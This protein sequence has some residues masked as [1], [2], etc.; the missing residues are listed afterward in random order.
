[1]VV[2]I[3][4]LGLVV[5]CAWIQSTKSLS[6]RDAVRDVAHHKEGVTIRDQ[7]NHINLEAGIHFPKQPIRSPGSTVSDPLSYWWGV[8]LLCPP[9]L[10][11]VSLAE[12]VVIGL[13]AAAI[14]EKTNSEVQKPSLEVILEF[15]MHD[16]IDTP[17]EHSGIQVYL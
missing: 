8:T 14:R 1:M 5:H 6:L 2:T 11:D 9:E 12:N 7:V 4:S 17:F 13:R 15:G 10:N 16:G 3:V